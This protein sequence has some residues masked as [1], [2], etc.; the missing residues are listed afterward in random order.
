MHRS[1]TPKEIGKILLTGGIYIYGAIVIIAASPRGY[2]G[3]RFDHLVLG[4]LKELKTGPFELRGWV[5]Q[6]RVLAT[7]T[8]F[9]WI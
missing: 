6:E 3:I 5:L 8:V 2:G 1:R 7:A 4:R 9:L